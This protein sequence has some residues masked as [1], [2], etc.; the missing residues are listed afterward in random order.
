MKK[1][2]IRYYY[3]R[4]LIECGKHF[5]WTNG[6]SADSENGNVLYPWMT[7]RQCQ[8]EAKSLGLKAVFISK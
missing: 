7:K 5:N 8:R 3:F 2:P 4:G 6:Y 1:H